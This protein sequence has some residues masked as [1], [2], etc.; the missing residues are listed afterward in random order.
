MKSN[1]ARRLSASFSFAR[2]AR[3]GIRPVRRGIPRPGALLRRLDLDRAVTKAEMRDRHLVGRAIIVKG[4]RRATPQHQTKYGRRILVDRR[5]GCRR[6]R[7]EIVVNG[8]QFLSRGDAPLPRPCA[9]GITGA[10]KIRC[11]RRAG[12]PFR[13][14][15]HAGRPPRHRPAARRPARIAPATTRCEAIPTLL[16]WRH[17]IRPSRISPHLQR[18]PLVVEP[19]GASGIHDLT[20][21]FDRTNEIDVL[22]LRNFDIPAIVQRDVQV[23]VAVE[24]GRPIRIETREFGR[25]TWSENV[26]VLAQPDRQHRYRQM[27]HPPLSRMGLHAIEQSL[28]HIGRVLI[29]ANRTA[30]PFEPI[31]EFRRQTGIASRRGQA[32]QH[33]LPRRVRRIRSPFPPRVMLRA[34]SP[35]HA[36]S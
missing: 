30:D 8:R 12:R 26:A 13:R 15:N 28:A 10:D 7:Q 14:P 19:I 6:R 2:R 11:A 35:R 34:R 16:A 5:R 4:I 20:Q 31:V 1:R 22:V 33:V 9:R 21:E 27:R 17:S 3:D 18:R 29:A 24:C 32:R 25:E 23:R 36:C